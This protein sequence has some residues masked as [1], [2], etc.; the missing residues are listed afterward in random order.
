ML[1]Q[2]AVIGFPR[3]WDKFEFIDARALHVQAP[4]I[5]Y[6][7]GHGFYTVLVSEHS[8]GVDIGQILGRY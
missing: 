5:L 1:G 2:Y 7:P 6:H 3:L 8:S 4:F